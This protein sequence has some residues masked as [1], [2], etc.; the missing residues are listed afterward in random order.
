MRS[1]NV[2]PSVAICKWKAVTTIVVTMLAGVV[3]L[4][5]FIAVYGKITYEGYVHF[6]FFFPKAHNAYM[7]MVMLDPNLDV[8]Y[9]F[10]FLVFFSGEQNYL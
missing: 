7:C 2:L 5:G 3:T 9:H 4:L 1:L 10:C 6:R 8:S